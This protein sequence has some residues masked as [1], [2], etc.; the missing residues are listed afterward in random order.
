MTRLDTVRQ[1]MRAFAD[2][3]GLSD[4]TREPRRYLWTDAFAVC[5]FLELHRQTGEQ[6]YLELALR[7][8]E[9]VHQVLGRR[10]PDNGR[11]GWLSGLSDDEAKR[12][13]TLGG[14]RIGKKLDERQ[15]D[16]A[17]DE[18]LEWDR[19]GQ[20]F[21]YLTKWMHALNAVAR[22]TGNGLFHHWARELAQV[23]HAA[24]TY[25]AADGSRRMYWKMSTDLSRPLVASMGQHD[26][27]DGW[28]TFSELQATGLRF[29]EWARPSLSSEI[30]ELAEICA[31]QRWTTSDALGIGGLL[32]DAWRLAQLIGVYHLP[33]SQRLA[34][35]MQDIDI[36]MR[37]FLQQNT[38]KYPI[39]YRLA[40]RELG[41]SIGLH[42]LE[43]M[44]RLFDDEPGFFDGVS[45]LRELASRL[46][47][48]MPLRGMI[49]NYWLD[50]AHQQHPG[51]RDHEDI[52]RVMLATTLAPDTFLR[53]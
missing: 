30:V 45:E 33:E 47:H 46:E 36:S 6:E 52:N 13:P 22:V 19:D 1:I 48:F 31:G 17:L 18:A 39:E 15:P 37:G 28:L 5:N 9:Q 24:F 7:L 44:V 50:P 35:L 41:M 40:F 16:E 29:A 34:A 12:H 2:D 10:H 20:Y 11:D 38:L 49:E 21:H 43:K 32:A 42:G 26:P 4:A 14:L 23:A 3:T 25:T 27:L 53:V 8:V 51:W